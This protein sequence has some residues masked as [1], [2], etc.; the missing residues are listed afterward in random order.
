MNLHSPEPQHTYTSSESSLESNSGSFLSPPPFQLKADN[1]G[2][3]PGGDG[4]EKS[5]NGKGKKGMTP[6]MEMPIFK[7]QSEKIELPGFS[8]SCKGELKATGNHARAKLE[9]ERGGALKAP[10]LS[11]APVYEEWAAK[12]FSAE[13]TLIDFGDGI[14][15]SLKGDIGAISGGSKKEKIGITFAKISLAVSGKVDK[16]TVQKDTTFCQLIRNHPDIMPLLDAGMSL[17]LTGSIDIK[18]DAGDAARLFRINQ[19]DDEIKVAQKEADE[20][21]E[22]LA[23]AKKNWASEKKKWLERTG[24]KLSGQKATDAFNKKKGKKLAQKVSEEAKKFTERKNTAERLAR[25][26]ENISKSMKSRFGK[27]LAKI[28]GNRIAKTLGK[29]LGKAAWVYGVY[30]TM[31]TSSKVYEGWEYLNFDGEGMKFDDMKSFEEVSPDSGGF[32][33]GQTGTGATMEQMDPDG[34]VDQ[35]AP[36]NGEGVELGGEG[37]IGLGKG[38]GAGTGSADNPENYGPDLGPGK[39]RGPFMGQDGGKATVPGTG[40]KGM[41]PES[42]SKKAKYLLKTNKGLAALWDLISNVKGA[43]LTQKQAEDFAETFQHIT[44]EEYAQMSQLLA[45][46]SSENVDVNQVLD[47]LKKAYKEIQEKK[48]GS[49]QIE[50]KEDQS[51]QDEGEHE[52]VEADAQGYIGVEKGKVNQYK[53]KPAIPPGMKSINPMDEHAHFIFPENESLQKGEICNMRI[54]VSYIDSQTGKHKF[55]PR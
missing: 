44:M 33:P 25:E 55:L 35:K 12:I 54:R 23:K 46:G 39:G 31:A 26:S 4:S 29:I 5:L 27:R 34:S 30:D 37:N 19:I 48:A 15:A 24:K 28:A 38:K 21:A 20:A 18:M 8:I 3:P 16:K 42:F 32:V 6:G 17:K 22:A 11:L 47:T 7:I 36:L 10:T 9:N 13:Q 53:P 52:L 1:P 45:R 41:D 49:D 2:I 14:K 43:R 51:A 50:E 40:G